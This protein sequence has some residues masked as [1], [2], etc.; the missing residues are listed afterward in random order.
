VVEVGW[1]AVRELKKHFALFELRPHKDG[2]THFAIDERFSE[3]MLPQNRQRNP[4][5]TGG[6]AAVE[7]HLLCN[8]EQ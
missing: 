1:D 8:P 4:N 7:R 5:L 6:A 2:S 3:L